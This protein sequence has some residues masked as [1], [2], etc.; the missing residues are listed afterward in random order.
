LLPQ[1]TREFEQ[2]GIAGGIV[3]DACIPGV[4]VAVD[5]HEFFRLGCT[6]NGCYRHLLHEPSLGQVGTDSGLAALRRQRKQLLAVRVA[7]CR[8]R[9]ARLARS[10]IQVGT[11]PDRG[12]GSPMDVHA[13]IDRDQAN[14]A[15]LLDQAGQRRIAEA[16]HHHDVA[17]DHT[18]HV[19]DGRDAPAEQ[20]L[21]VAII[22][23]ERPWIG[24]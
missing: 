21:D 20:G 23:A 5:Q 15:P 13:G 1:H 12:A 10:V 2:R 3:T 17:A 11:A 14:A 22:A 19:L 6:R 9:D 8:H 18:F 7:H 4:V 24:L 16:Q